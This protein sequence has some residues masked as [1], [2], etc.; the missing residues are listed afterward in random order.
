M[1]RASGLGEKYVNDGT[2]AGI[3]AKFRAVDRPSG[4]AASPAGPGRALPA[5][6]PPNKAETAQSATALTPAPRQS[7]APADLSTFGEIQRELGVGRRL[8][9]TGPVDPFLDSLIQ[10]AEDEQEVSLFARVKRKIR[11]RAGGLAD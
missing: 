9:G 2:A 4:A 10:T 1:E 8:L 7:A 11:Q 6:T 3:L 5:A